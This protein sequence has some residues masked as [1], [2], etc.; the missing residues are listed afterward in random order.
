M[1][2]LLGLSTSS[3]YLEWVVAGYGDGSRVVLRA[4]GWCDRVADPES[5]QVIGPQWPSLQAFVIDEVER[6]AAEF[7]VVT[8]RQLVPRPLPPLPHLGQG[9]HFAVGGPVVP[10]DPAQLVNA[11]PEYVAGRQTLGF[12]VV[13]LGVGGIAMFDLEALAAEQ[14]GYS[15]DGGWPPDW[16][17][18]GVELVCGDPLIMST[19]EPWPVF[20]AAH[21][22]GQWSTERVAPSIDTFW[23][24]LR[25]L[26]RLST[27]K[28]DRLPAAAR[29]CTRRLS[30][31]C[32]DDFEAERFWTDQVDGAG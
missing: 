30:V 6:L 26:H 21:G 27:T 4:D 14:R 32:G 7:D 9:E 13:E 18:I 8:R 22:E 20:N 25:A 23:D 17:V 10:S 1:P 29:E 16:L 28:V 19:I 15:V 3:P 31:L 12:D 11:P 24:C 2:N 5:R